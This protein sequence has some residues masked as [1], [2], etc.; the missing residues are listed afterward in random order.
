MVSFSVRYSA[1]S[2][3]ESLEFQVWLVIFSE[4]LIT[5]D[6]TG[7]VVETMVVGAPVVDESGIVVGA[8][9]VDGA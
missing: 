2:M 3:S 6:I 1:E 9:V 4:A 5:C 7:S 8:C